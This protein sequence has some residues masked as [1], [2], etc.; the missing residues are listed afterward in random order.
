M[1]NGL[2]IGLV[3]LS[4]VLAGG[5]ARE[6]GGGNALIELGSKKHTRWVSAVAQQAGAETWP[7]VKRL[8][9]TMT[10]T[11]DG[12]V[13]DRTTHDWDVVGGKDTINFN[14]KTLVADLKSEPTTSEQTQAR[15]IHLASTFALLLPLKLSEPGMT[16]KHVG[17]GDFDGRT[18]DVLTMTTQL[19][20]PNG[21]FSAKLYVDPLKVLVRA[22]EAVNDGQDMGTMTF[23]AY[24]NFN[25][26][27][28]ST[29]RRSVDDRRLITFTDI[30]VSR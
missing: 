15:G 19:P 4:L 8:K 16:T 1:R 7:G 6:A 18:Y 20:P 11:Q 10:E 13:V 25:G 22:V 14:G 23:D 3:C 9:F 12:K 30:S 28:L 2:N 17:A 5:C 29:K 26:L 21:L 24:Q 27:L